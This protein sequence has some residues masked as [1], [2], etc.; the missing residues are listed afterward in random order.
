MIKLLSYQPAKIFLLLFFFGGALFGCLD[1]AIV[2]TVGTTITGIKH[3]V[4]PDKASYFLV[5]QDKGHKEQSTRGVWYYFNPGDLHIKYELESIIRDF[6]LLEKAVWSRG[7]YSV[8]LEKRVDTRK[9]NRIVTFPF[10]K[11]KQELGNN[12]YGQWN[13]ELFINSTCAGKK[14]FYLI[15]ESEYERLIQKARH[16]ESTSDMKYAKDLLIRAEK[17]NPIAYKNRTFYADSNRNSEQN[18]AQSDWKVITSKGKIL[19]GAGESKALQPFRMDKIIQIQFGQKK[20][21]RF[22][23][24]QCYIGVSPNGHRMFITHRTRKAHDFFPNSRRTDNRNSELTVLETTGN[25][26]TVA[27]Y[28]CAIDGVSWLDND[29][30]FLNINKR[31]SSK[32]YTKKG[33]INVNN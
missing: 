3:I 21:G 32:W 6:W 9:H 29:T 15:N 11:V 28:A 22:T 23:I 27:Y 10:K 14:P 25:N 13:I 26:N 30:L 16:A 2:Y 5:Y 20:F 24:S 12:W 7:K 17:A 33:P 19:I 8:T 31:V 18:K 1:Y 4:W